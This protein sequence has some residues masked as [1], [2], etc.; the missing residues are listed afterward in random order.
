MQLNPKPLRGKYRVVKDSLVKVGNY[1]S[2]HKLPE[3]VLNPGWYVLPQDTVLSIVKIKETINSHEFQMTVPKSH[4]NKKNPWAG[5]RF[6]N[7]SCFE[8]F[9]VEVEK[10]P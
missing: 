10:L 8:D 2:G 4:N 7:F 3:S 1:Y 9:D 6:T 5:I